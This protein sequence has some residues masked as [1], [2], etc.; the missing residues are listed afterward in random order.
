MD[1]ADMVITEAEKADNK[2]A[3][4]SKSDA[5]VSKTVLYAAST[6]LYMALTV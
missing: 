6:V 4:K 2:R 1:A 3:A 5:L